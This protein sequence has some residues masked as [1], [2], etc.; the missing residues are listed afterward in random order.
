[1]NYNGEEKESMLNTFARRLFGSQENKP[2]DFGDIPGEELDSLVDS[3]SKSQL[4]RRSKKNKIKGKLK[5]YRD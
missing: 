5:K 4:K 1:M 3:K 2:S